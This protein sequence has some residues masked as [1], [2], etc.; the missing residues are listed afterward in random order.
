MYWC[1]VDLVLNKLQ[2]GK[3]G[4]LAGHVMYGDPFPIHLAVNCSSKN[5]RT[6]FAKCGGA[7]LIFSCG[8]GIVKDHYVIWQTYKRLKYIMK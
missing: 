7:H 8:G 6:M 2:Q 3:S 4:D 1:P 5:V